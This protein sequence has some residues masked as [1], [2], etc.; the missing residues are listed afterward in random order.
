M[1]KGLIKKSRTLDTAVVIAILGIIEAN[2]SLISDSLGEYQGF[3]Y[4]GLS[5]V[6]AVL[7]MDTTGPIGD[8]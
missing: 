4:I 1:Y 3:V 6:I 2:F 7:R 5:I 8:K